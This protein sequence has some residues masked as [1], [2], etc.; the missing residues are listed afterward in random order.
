MFRSIFFAVGIFLLLLGGQ[1]LLV[2]KLIV[3]NRAT[4]PKFLN[5]NQ[6][7]QVAAPFGQLPNANVPFGQSGFRGGQQPYYSQASALRNAP[8]QV[9]RQR[10]YQTR[11]WMPWSLL[12][13]GAVVIMYSASMGRN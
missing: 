3:S 6:Q 5:G 1:S 10:V 4:V 2:D 7:G 8:A 9:R 12:A 13:A 11:E